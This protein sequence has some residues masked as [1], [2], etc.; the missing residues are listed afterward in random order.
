M[1]RRHNIA[2]VSTVAIIAVLRMKNSVLHSR[3]KKYSLL[4]LNAVVVPK[5]FRGL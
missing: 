5:C 2:M 4:Y 1:P 3:N